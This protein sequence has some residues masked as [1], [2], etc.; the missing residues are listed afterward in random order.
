MLDSPASPR[1]DSVSGLFVRRCN[2]CGLE[3]K[4]GPLH[5]LVVVAFYLAHL[6][7]PGETLLGALAILVCLLSHGADASLKTTTHALN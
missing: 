2:N 3:L 4:L 5:P 6:G 1:I 7:M